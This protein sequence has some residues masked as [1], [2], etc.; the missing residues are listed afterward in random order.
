MEP[1]ALSG[2]PHWH[3]RPPLGG[4]A[5][6][7]WPHGGVFLRPRAPMRWRAL[8]SLEVSSPSTHW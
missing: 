8:S 4:R 6:V 1:V 5:T 7:E 3:A 2:A